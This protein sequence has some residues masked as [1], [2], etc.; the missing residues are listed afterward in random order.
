MAY[1][2]VPPGY[3]VELCDANGI[4]LALLTLY[5]EDLVAAREA[6]RCGR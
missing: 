3:Q 2:G 1:P 6:E 5:E 4:T